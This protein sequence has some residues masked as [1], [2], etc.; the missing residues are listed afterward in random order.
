[1]LEEN[2]P[3]KEYRYAL[4]E[5]EMFKERIRNEEEV[6]GKILKSVNIIIVTSF[7]LTLRKVRDNAYYFI[8]QI[9]ANNS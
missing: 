3:N 1:M 6:Q 9:F 5:H 8:N 4:V 7:F 2:R